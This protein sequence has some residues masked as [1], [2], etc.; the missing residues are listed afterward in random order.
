MQHMRAVPFLFG[1]F[2]DVVFGAYRVR[3]QQKYVEEALCLDAEMK[4]K[5]IC[6]FAR[7]IW[8]L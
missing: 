1:L 6:L 3:R 5:T 7:R 8:L 2:C 4:S